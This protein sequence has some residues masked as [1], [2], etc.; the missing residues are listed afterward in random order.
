MWEER[1]HFPPFVQDFGYQLLV[2]LYAVITH[3]LY[4]KQERAA[5][6]TTFMANVPSESLCF[7]G[8]TFTITGVDYLGPYQIKLSKGNS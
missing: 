6:V 8:K 2:G 5:P 4:F 1:K 3:C 7:K